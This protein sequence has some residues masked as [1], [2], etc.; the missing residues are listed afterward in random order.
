MT[1]AVGFQ[2]MNLGGHKH[3]VNCDLQ[4]KGKGHP[5]G[6]TNEKTSQLHAAFG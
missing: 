1:L 3:S 6:L 2:H 4:L 5:S